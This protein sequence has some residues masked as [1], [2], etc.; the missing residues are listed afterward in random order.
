MLKPQGSERHG[1]R[2]GTVNRTRVRTGRQKKRRDAESGEDGCAQRYAKVC[3][4]GRRKWDGKYEE[5][6]SR[7]G[8]G[9]LLEKYALCVRWARS[10]YARVQPTR[11][12]EVRKVER[13]ATKA[14]VDHGGL[15]EDVFPCRGGRCATRGW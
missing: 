6:I 9:D 14:P 8:I 2:L 10:K 11:L 7:R 3:V 1:A 13:G 15:D 4:A 12:V 5:E